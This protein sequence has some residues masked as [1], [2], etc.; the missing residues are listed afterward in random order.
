M[1]CITFRVIYLFIS[2]VTFPFYHILQF[3][4]LTILF[5]IT[6]LKLFI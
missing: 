6:C 4:K 2:D 3:V 5:E 1:I